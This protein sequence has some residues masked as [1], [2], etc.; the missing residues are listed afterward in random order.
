MLIVD[1]QVHIWKDAKLGAHHRQ[2]PTFSKDDLLA[3]MDAGGIT[4]A[5]ICPPFSLPEVNVLASE[6]A[7]QHPDRLCVMGF[8]PIDKAESRDTIRTWKH[9]PGMKGLRWVLNQPHH[10]Q[11]FE[12]GTLDWVWPAAEREDLPVALLH[13]D[14]LAAIGKVAARHPGLKLAIDHLGCVSGTKDRAA[15]ATLPDLLA[16]AKYKNVS[17]KLSGAPSNSSEGYPWRN[18]H[19]DIRRIYDAFGPSRC[20]WGTDITRL[21]CTW[22]QAV[23]MFTEELPW[24]KGRDLELVMGKALCNWLGWQLPKPS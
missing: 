14:N 20:F 19:D 18:I 13:N 2:I 16:L 23:T 24:L 1:S 4:A 17:V 11:W 22:K 15:F 6:A 12:D 8:F 3:E 9:R 7:R 21:H 10:K 5:V